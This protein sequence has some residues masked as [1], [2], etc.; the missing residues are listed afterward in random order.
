MNSADTQPEPMNE[1][2]VH[3]I[4]KVPV[5][6]EIIRLIADTHLYLRETVDVLRGFGLDAMTTLPH[7]T[8]PDV[9]VTDPYHLL[10]EVRDAVQKLSDTLSEADPK[11]IE[12]IQAVMTN[13]I[14]VRI[15]GL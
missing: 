7:F 10:T 6:F 5:P 9:D 11:L 13:P 4:I 3:M 8:N 15:L 14:V 2:A 1:T 12:K